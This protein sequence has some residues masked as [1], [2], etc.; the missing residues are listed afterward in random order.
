MLLCWTGLH[1]QI[2]ILLFSN[3]TEQQWETCFTLT[4]SGID[5][6]MYD[7]VIRLPDEVTEILFETLLS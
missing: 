1:F 5:N 6:W 7:K 2:L 3:Y 4:L